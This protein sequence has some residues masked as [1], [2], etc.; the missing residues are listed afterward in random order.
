[1]K[2]PKHNEIKSRLADKMTVK[3]ISKVLGVSTKTV[4]EVRSAYPDEFKKRKPKPPKK[5]KL[6]TQPIFG[7]V[8]TDIYNRFKSEMS[9]RGLTISGLLRYILKQRYVDGRYNH[10]NDYKPQSDCS[11]PDS[12]I[13][14]NHNSNL[15]RDEV[16]CGD[17][18]RVESGGDE[19]E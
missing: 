15:D 14:K 17:C 10:D 2:H 9:A 3:G 19:N 6:G 12:S 1:M 18:G 11:C 8:P 4:M 13:I 16:V 7:R 5:D